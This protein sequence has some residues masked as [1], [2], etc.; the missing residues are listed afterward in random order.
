LHER[1]HACCCRGIHASLFGGEKVLFNLAS[2]LIKRLNA[3]LI[4]IDLKIDQLSR[5]SWVR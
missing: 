1:S 4:Q 3:A 5:E 2:S